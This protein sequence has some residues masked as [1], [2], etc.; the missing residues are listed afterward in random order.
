MCYECLEDFEVN[1]VIVGVLVWIGIW[2]ADLLGWT[3]WI[4]ISFGN[5]I[6]MCCDAM[7]MIYDNVWWYMMMYDDVW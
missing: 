5:M 6:M 1:S 4:E 2:I 3:M 7:I